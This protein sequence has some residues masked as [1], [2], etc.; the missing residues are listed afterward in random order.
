MMSDCISKKSDDVPTSAEETMKH[1]RT[2]EATPDKI[3][4][5]KRN[6]T[7]VAI[8]ETPAKRAKGPP[9]KSMNPR[10]NDKQDVKDF[11][12]MCDFMMEQFCYSQAEEEILVEALNAIVTLLLDLFD[13]FISKFGK[14]AVHDQKAEWENRLSE[15][16]RRL[17]ELGE[18]WRMLH[19]P[20]MILQESVVLD[21]E[22]ADV[23]KEESDP[24]KEP[25]ELKEGGGENEKEVAE[26]DICVEEKEVASL[27]KKVAE[28]K[29]QSADQ[30]EQIAELEYKCMEKDQWIAEL[31]KRES[32]WKSHSSEEELMKE[33]V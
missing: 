19:A 11:C 27:K 3:T 5:S 21:H 33:K 14:P 8:D 30:K 6:P 18:E 25:A 13:L 26:G 23:E 24:E 1:V 31:E 22:K 20:K 9:E 32:E 2:S 16:E 15:T 17:S 10:L 12:R 29:K 28:L 7:D 4:Q